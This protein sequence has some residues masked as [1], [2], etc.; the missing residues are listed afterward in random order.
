[1]ATAQ[2]NGELQ[3]TPKRRRL[4]MVG[5]GLLMVAA[6]TTLA[7]N[8]F[9][10]TLVFFYSPTDLIDA[11][12]NPK[13]QIRVGGL[14]EEKSLLKSGDGLSV[15]FTITDLDNRLPVTFKGAL[16]DLFREGQ[17]VVAEGY[18]V[19]GLFQAKHVLAKH[20]ENYMPKE[21]ADS[22]KKSGKWKG[23]SKQ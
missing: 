21:V 13:K 4:T 7:L 16:P 11:K 17:G 20:D 18:L 1:M 6:A 10:D 3:M 12:T 19:D 15:S 8:A 22:L 2:P 5:L 14:V 9:E 23:G